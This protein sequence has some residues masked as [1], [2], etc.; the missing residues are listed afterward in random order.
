MKQQ[1]AEDQMKEDAASVKKDHEDD[2]M[3]REKA[4]A[5]IAQDR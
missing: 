4:K 3:A 5:Q 2:R 1:Q